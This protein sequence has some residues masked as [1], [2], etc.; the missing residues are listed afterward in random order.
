MRVDDSRFRKEK[1]ADSKICGY[2]WTGPKSFFKRSEFLRSEVSRSEFSRSE[3]GTDPNR[4]M[5]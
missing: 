5:R 3:V 1:V 4:L 2:V